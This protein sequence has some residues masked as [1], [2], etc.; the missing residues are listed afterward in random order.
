MDIKLDPNGSFEDNLERLLETIDDADLRQ[1][2]RDQTQ[3]IINLGDE[4]SLSRR[5]QLNTEFRR[6]ASDRLNKGDS[7][8]D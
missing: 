2:I 1:I 5:E 3:T 8:E 4:S 6:L 7:N